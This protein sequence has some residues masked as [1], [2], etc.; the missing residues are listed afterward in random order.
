MEIHRGKNFNVMLDFVNGY[1]MAP[2]RAILRVPVNL[3][4]P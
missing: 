4:S 1:E 2:A 3:V